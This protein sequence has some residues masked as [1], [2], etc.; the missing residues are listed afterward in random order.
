ML[1][2][3]LGGFFRENKHGPLRK[4]VMFPPKRV[5]ER[6]AKRPLE[7]ST[8]LAIYGKDSCGAVVSPFFVAITSLNHSG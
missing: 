7:M 1:R 2:L 5:A 8:F 6:S 3:G 4:P